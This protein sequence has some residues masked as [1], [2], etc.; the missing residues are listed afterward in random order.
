V[1]FS[2]RISEQFDPSFN[3]KE[4]TNPSSKVDYYRQPSKE[5]IRD[6]RDYRSLLRPNR[7][8]HA[9]MLTVDSNWV[10][11]EPSKHVLVSQIS[12]KQVRTTLNLYA[13][14]EDSFQIRADDIVNINLLP[15]NSDK[16]CASI[17]FVSGFRAWEFTAL[18][19]EK[20]IFNWII[21]SDSG[22]MAFERTKAELKELENRLQRKH[23]EHTH[24]REL[25]KDYHHHQE[26]S[27]S[28]K[29][30]N[31]LSCSPFVPCLKIPFSCE[32]A[33]PFDLNE[34]ALISLF[35]ASR[36]PSISGVEE[37]ASSWHIHFGREVDVVEADKMFQSD[38]FVWKGHRFYF[39][40]WRLSK[41]NVSWTIPEH[42]NNQSSVTSKHGSISQPNKI[43]D[44]CV[45]SSP[46]R[47]M[48]DAVVTNWDDVPKFVKKR[49]FPES[50]ISEP[51]DEV[52][53]VKVKRKPV[54]KR[55]FVSTTSLSKPIVDDYS[56]MQVVVNDHVVDDNSTLRTVVDKLENIEV[57][58]ENGMIEV[59]DDMENELDCPVLDGGCARSEGFFRLSRELKE[60][61]RFS[62]VLEAFSS[63]SGTNS[64]ATTATTKEF[65]SA[66]DSSANGRSSRV[67]NR[68][69]LLHQ[70]IANA[71]SLDLFK[72]SPLQ[73]TQKLVCLRNSSIHSFGLVLMEHADPGDLIIEYVGE[74]VRASVANIREWKY[75]REYCGDGIASS[76]L[77]RL[78]D[79][80]VID[81][82]QQG[83][84]AR[85]INHSCDPNCVAKTITLNGS[86][87]IVMY[88]KKHIRAGEEI[89]YDYKFPTEKDP[90]KKVKCLC[91]SSNCRKTLN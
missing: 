8:F 67:Q 88:A 57:L 32:S 50:H 4:I 25:L 38:V 62:G 59:D 87:R 33:L 58:E 51:S 27:P 14:L 71:S 85:F 54:T 35:P 47:L 48:S 89:T 39:E 29:P 78:D 15:I 21:T 40:K 72:V 13:L 41:G 75:E 30:V 68:R 43:T 3:A 26:S 77:F 90:K 52:V 23:E 18:P 37:G 22:G 79:I 24:K 2:K 5:S 44:N 31:N 56:A 65:S 81:A 28:K 64:V 55:P 36:F 17:L 9:S 76:Y 20:N 74:L 84:L 73:S 10:R 1:Q 34:E 42:Y 61:V 69:P 83:N 82:S 16:L 63:V 45:M 11:G 12:S 70:S 19:K 6:P 80:M 60:L 53:K 7:E 86:K 46:S 49:A 91:G 66:S